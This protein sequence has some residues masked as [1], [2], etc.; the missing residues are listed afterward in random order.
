MQNTC[1]PTAQVENINA[2]GSWRDELAH[3]IYSPEMWQQL[4]PAPY[5]YAR[6]CLQSNEE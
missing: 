3:Y 2:Q 1:S 6:E 4:L 5:A